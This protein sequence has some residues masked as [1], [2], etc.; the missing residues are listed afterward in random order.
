MPTDSSVAGRPVNSKRNVIEWFVHGSVKA[1]DL[2]KAK[3]EIGSKINK[4]SQWQP[5]NHTSV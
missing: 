5:E 1:Y 3:V 2:D 4:I